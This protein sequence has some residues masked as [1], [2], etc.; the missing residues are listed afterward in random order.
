MFTGDGCHLLSARVWLTLSGRATWLNQPLRLILQ[1]R[2]SIGLAPISPLSL[3]T[4]G[5][6]HPVSYSIV[7]LIVR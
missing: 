1:L 3:P 7:K 2:D 5:K 6:R 4:R